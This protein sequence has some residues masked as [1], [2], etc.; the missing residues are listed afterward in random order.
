M[1]YLF[2]TFVLIQSLLFAAPSGYVPRN[3]SYLKGMDGF[4]D[5]LLTMHFKLMKGT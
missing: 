2:F 5:E 1:K 3:F 4:S